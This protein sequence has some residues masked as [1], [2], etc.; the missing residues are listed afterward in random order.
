MKRWTEAAINKWWELQKWPI[1]ADFVTTSAVNDIEMWMD[2]T[3]NP[4]L[5]R[6]ELEIVKSTGL[7]SVRIFLSYIVWR[8][9]PEQFE[10]NFEF[11]LQ[12]A[13]EVGLTVMPI[14]FDDCAFDFG[15]EPKYGPQSDPIPGIHNSRWVPSPGFVIQDD[16]NQLEVCKAYVD[17]VVG[18][19]S[20]DPRIIIWD[21][22]NEAG[23]TGRCEKCLPLLQHAFEWARE[24]DPIQP[25]TA[26][27]YDFSDGYRAVNEYCFEQSDIISVHTYSDIEG[28]KAVVELAKKYGRPI[29]V[30]EWM[31]R[32][33]GS[34]IEA[35]LPYFHQEKIG[36]WQWGVIL[37]KTQTN[38]NWNTMNGGTPEPNPIL[39]QHDILYPDTTPY[40]A[41]EIALI[42]KLAK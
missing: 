19:H 9:E 13:H 31:H 37:G 14:L 23:N 36:C 5:V 7:N 27:S 10:R 32:P 42:K 26:G 29:L 3:F 2:A 17:A 28:T 30:T 20:K 34:T 4:G 38:L 16:P 33:N 41:E 18:K 24:N 39:W 8:E 35:I 12:T 11:F 6:K 1:G 25:L 21:L 15:S 40:R 22:Y